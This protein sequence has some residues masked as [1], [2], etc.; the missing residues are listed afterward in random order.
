MRI[1][2]RRDGG[3]ARARKSHHY[4]IPAFRPHKVRIRSRVQ[5]V[6]FIFFRRAKFDYPNRR[7]RAQG[8]RRLFEKK[9]TQLLE[10]QQYRSRRR[11]IGLRIDFEVFAARQPPRRLRRECSRRAQRRE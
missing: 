1:F 11:V 8:K 9:R 7:Q 3:M 5:A 2:V 4:V 10:L 6:R